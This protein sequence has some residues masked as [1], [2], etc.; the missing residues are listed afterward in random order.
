MVEFL[1]MFFVG[2]A[3][4]EVATDVGSSTYDY[5]EPKITQGV[6]YV[7]DKFDSEEQE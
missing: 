1:V 7:K 6:D 4:I 2:V 5:V 3:A